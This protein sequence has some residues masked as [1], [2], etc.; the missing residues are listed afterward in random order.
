MKTI[1]ASVGG[2]LLFIVII[3]IGV[4]ITSFFNTDYEMWLLHMIFL[5]LIVHK[6]KTEDD[7]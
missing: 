5:F 4:S 6:L 2:L 7:E 3:I 1:W